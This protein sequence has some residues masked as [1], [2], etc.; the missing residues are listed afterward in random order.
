MWQAAQ[1]PA[2]RWDLGSGGA[3]PALGTKLNAFR[4]RKA[5]ALAKSKFRFLRELPNIKSTF[6]NSR[7]AAQTQSEHFGELCC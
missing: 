6:L 5:R 1:S 4:A 2:S 3:R 7:K